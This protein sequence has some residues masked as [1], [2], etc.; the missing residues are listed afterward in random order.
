[1]R[2]EEINNIKKEI[3]QAVDI[4]NIGSTKKKE[5]ANFMTR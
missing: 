5:P 4:S 3:E 1:M 2:Q